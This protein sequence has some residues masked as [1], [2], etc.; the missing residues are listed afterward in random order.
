MTEPKGPIA[1]LPEPNH[2][3]IVVKDLGQAARYY[4]SHFG[5]GPF[6]GAEMDMKRFAYHYRGRPS[7][8]RVR[9]AAGYCGPM[10]VELFQPLEGESIYGEFLQQKGEGLHHLGFVVED[11]DQTL[12]ALVHEG[13]E[14]IAHGGSPR[15]SFAYLDTGKVGGVVFEILSYSPFGGQAGAAG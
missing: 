3:G 9:V 5:W 14:Q 4:E 6:R 11:F 13:L 12:K 15:G 8:A 2:L 1:R 7:T 10:P